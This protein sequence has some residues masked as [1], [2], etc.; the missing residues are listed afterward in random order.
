MQKDEYT[1]NNARMSK[2]VMLQPTNGLWHLSKSEEIATN[3]RMEFTGIK[4]YMCI[5]GI[6]LYYGEEL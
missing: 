6:L 1:L 2:N 4:R 5:R 3:A